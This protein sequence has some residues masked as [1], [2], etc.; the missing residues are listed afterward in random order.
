[1]IEIY[2]NTT[3]NNKN[4]NYQKVAE[5]KFDGTEDFV[6]CSN[7]VITLDRRYKEDDLNIELIVI[8]DPTVNAF[9]K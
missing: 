3:K 8:K 5:Y 4:K 7:D 6:F 1:M 2:K 9:V